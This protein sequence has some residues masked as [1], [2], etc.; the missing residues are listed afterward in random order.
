MRTDLLNSNDE[1]RAMPLAQFIAEAIAILESGA[2]EIIVPHA[3]P[4][5]RAAGPG[6]GAFTFA[7]NDQASAGAAV[8]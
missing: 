6:D 4:I 2:D 3:Q 5:R 8:V 7:F 1:P